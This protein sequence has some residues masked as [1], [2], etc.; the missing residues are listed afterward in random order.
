MNTSSKKKFITLV[1]VALL[2]LIAGGSTL[3]YLSSKAETVENT[4]S[5]VRVSC[6]VVE[7]ST[8]YTSSTV[9]VST[10]SNVTV[11]NTGNTPAFIRATILVTWK[12]EDGRVYAT[13][14]EPGAG[15]DYIL[16][17]NTSDWIEE[18]GFY[19]YKSNIPAGGATSA[20]ITYASQLTPGPMGADNTQYKLSIEILAEAIQAEGMCVSKAQDAWTVARNG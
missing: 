14:P 18:D 1:S 6:A 4:F 15:K 19:Y 10:K 5:P 13:K 7:N 16:Q 17:L 3:A 11:K 8:E 12:S 2:I 20:L 9:S